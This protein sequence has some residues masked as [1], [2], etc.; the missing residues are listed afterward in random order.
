MSRENILYNNYIFSPFFPPS[1]FHFVTYIFS[2]MQ[3]LHNSNVHTQTNF[4]QRWQIKFS[5]FSGENIQYKMNILFLKKWFIFFIDLLPW[6]FYF[7]PLSLYSY[8][9][10]NC[11]MG[12]LQKSSFFIGQATKRGGGAKRVCH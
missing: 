5:F 9:S 8:V 10:K 11:N 7:W 1:F 2:K 12:K 3:R 6:I 4:L